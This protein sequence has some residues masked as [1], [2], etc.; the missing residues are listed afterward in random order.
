MKKTLSRKQEI[1]KLAK[2]LFLTK[3]Y[4]STT[5]AD[6]MQTLEIAK[7]TI[8]HYFK[9][10]EAMFEAVIEEI[11]E[12]MVTQVE[13][14][15]NMTM[16]FYLPSKFNSD[17]VPNPSREDV[18]IVNIEGGYY[19]VLRYSGRASDG[20][21]IKHKDILEKELKKKLGDDGFAGLAALAQCKHKVAL[22]YA[23]TAQESSNEKYRQAGLW[24]EALTYIDQGDKA[25]AES[26]Y[27]K[28]LE[29]QPE[30]SSRNEV[31]SYAREGVQGLTNIRKKEN[32]PVACSK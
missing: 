26:M 7:G 31:D 13:K 19:A 8:Y 10:K 12:S 4:E 1:L 16:Q 9:S 11:T 25:K 20:N 28:L 15:G 22:G 3:G 29:A 14:N 5:M 18:R 21:F 17:N 27:P 6:I 30:I 32:L 24:L 2:E 23:E